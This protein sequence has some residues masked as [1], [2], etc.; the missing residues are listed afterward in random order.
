M[1]RELFVFAGQSNMMGASALPPTHNLN[2]RDCTEYKFKSRL[3]GK[4]S[5]DFVPVTYECGEFI[6]KDMK[7]AYLN[8][9]EMG[10]SKLSDYQ[11]TAYFAPSMC[12]SMGT[13]DK[14]CRPFSD[15]SE[16]FHQPAP[17]L[18]PYFCEQWEK[19]YGGASIAHIAKGSTK[20]EYF[21]TNDENEGS[22]EVFKGKCIAFFDDANKFYGEDNI[23]KK[24]LIWLQGE[25]NY[26]DSVN[27]YLDKLNKLKDYADEI[28]FD[29]IMI[30]RVGYWFRKECSN[31]MKAQEIF[32][33]QQ[34]NCYIIT[35]AI[36]LMPDNYIDCDNYFDWYTKM[37]EEKFRY[38]RDSVFGYEN[39]HINEAGFM[40]AAETAAKNAYLI[41]KENKPPLLEE[42]LVRYI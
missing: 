25:S 7:E 14:R 1:K 41:L 20:I 35:R 39:S 34:E 28:G 37:P 27:K 4:N 2:I 17:S 24:T 6:Y 40:I 10:Q 33:Q 18:A 21:Y 22:S 38:C 3:I 5:G 42:D 11:R 8:Q 30:I 26:A 12:N 13:S 19:L 31:I 15:F 32:C 9:D 16:S 36:S 23:G 29:K